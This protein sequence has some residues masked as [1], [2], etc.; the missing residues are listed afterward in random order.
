[1]SVAAS[2]RR[3]FLIG[4]GLTL[5]FLLTAFAGPMIYSVDPNA[6]NLLVTLAP[7]GEDHPFGADQLGRDVFARVLHGAHYSAGIAVAVIALSL[8]TGTVLAGLAMWFGGMLSTVLA[9]FSDSVYA[10]PGLLVVI[11]VAGVLGGGA[12]VIIFLLWFVKWPEYFRL[13]LATGQQIM[14][15]D[16][17]VASRLAGA[18]G[19]R[20]FQL[21]ILP[22]MLPYLLSLGALSVGQIVLSIAT[23]GFLGVGIAPPQAEWGMMINDLRIYWH[24]AP[25][26]LATP[27]V[28]ILW[29]VLA[30]LILSQSLPKP[31]VRTLEPHA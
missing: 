18:S 25:V 12:P 14:A 3:P 2:R 10:L 11:L 20:I 8:A 19:R 26:Q 23:L 28:A 15:S 7:P 30:L 13:C 31:E 22:I 6:Q 24:I 16:H 17:V 29:V 9:L 4:A 27:A 21:Q 5:G 1:V